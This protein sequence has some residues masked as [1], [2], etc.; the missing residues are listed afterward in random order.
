M[1]LEQLSNISMPMAALLAS[2]IGATATI[3]ASFL[4]LRMAWKKELLAR[5]NQKPVTKKSS[6]G[7][8]LALLAL[9][10]ASAVG[11][12]AL[13]YYLG[14]KGRTDT[15]ALEA[16]LRSKIEQLNVSALRLEKVSLNGADAIAQQVRDEERRNRGLEGV[17]A[18][19]RLEKCVAA[20]VVEGQAACNESTAHPVRLCTEIPAAANV[21]AIDLYA[22][23]EGDARP[24]SENRVIAGNDF[25]GGRFT[26][27]SERLIGDTAKQVCQDLLH[28]NSEHAVNGR[29]VVR[30]GA[31]AN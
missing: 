20:G 31:A 1:A 8:I 5:A 19:V 9:L 24:W 6:R 26:N 21:S 3:T 14:L 2:L 12:F 17:A 15:V 28:W 7:P 4:N 16:E 10:L 18:M 30:Y 13:S 29:M 23:P 22:R 11:G 25:G 27:R